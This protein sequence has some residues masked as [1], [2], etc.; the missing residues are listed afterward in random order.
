MLALLCGP[1]P[2]FLKV[3]RCRCGCFNRCWA[4]CIYPV[5][6]WH[7]QEQGFG[8]M[9]WCMLR[10]DWKAVA[11]LAAFA[12]CCY[13]VYDDLESKVGDVERCCGV[14]MLLT[15]SGLSTLKLFDVRQCLKWISGL[16]IHILARHGSPVLRQ[17]LKWIS[18]LQIHIL[19]RHGSPGEEYGIDMTSRYQST[20]A[21]QNLARKPSSRNERPKK[22]EKKRSKQ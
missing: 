16:Q 9:Q 21:S 13:I 2:R 22:K 11:F 1:I 20:H 14:I 12:S 10:G 8:S 3:N 17:C 7:D 5:A 15:L 19:A 6:L 4:L 18:G